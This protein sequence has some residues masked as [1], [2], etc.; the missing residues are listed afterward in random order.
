MKQIGSVE[1]PQE[2]LAVLKV[3]KLRKTP[4]NRNSS[5][6]RNAFSV[7]TF[8]MPTEAM[9]QRYIRETGLRLVQSIL[10]FQTMG[11]LVIAPSPDDAKIEAL[12]RVV[13]LPGDTIEVQTGF[14][15]RN[16][17]LTA[18]PAPA[19]FSTPGFCKNER[20][21]LTIAE[22]EACIAAEGKPFA[23]VKLT[24]AEGMVYVLGDYRTEV[25]L[26][27]IIGKGAPVG[28]LTPLTELK[29]RA[30]WLLRPTGNPFY[31]AL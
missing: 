5:R 22:V 27:T 18:A 13:G 16:G 28:F 7:T 19:A 2:A 31:R 10:L 23:Q 4:P 24:V 1:I 11:Q 20:L 12:R 21:S 30:A 3:G 15:I 14:L 8:Q 9:R 26:T 6:A 17:T 25:R 29:G